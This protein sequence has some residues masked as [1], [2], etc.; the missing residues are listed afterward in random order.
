MT[1]K[2]NELLNILKLMNVIRD[3]ND[4]NKWNKFDTDQ[5]CESI[6][7][8]FLVTTELSESVEWFRDKTKVGDSKAFDKFKEELV[9]VIIRYLDIMSA[10]DTLDNWKFVFYHAIEFDVKHK[11]YIIKSNNE[12]LIFDEDG[13]IHN[14]N[15]L[16]IKSII[17]FDWNK[18]YNIPVILDLHNRICSDLSKDF[19]NYYNDDITKEMFSYQLMCAFLIFCVSCDSIFDNIIYDIHKKNKINSLRGIKHG[20]KTV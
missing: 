13:N 16:S 2:R 6:T 20:N 5:D 15:D 18:K 19:Y 8:L 17:Q 14:T 9:D 7:K 3:T 10:Y 12:Y 1:D 4:K 11:C